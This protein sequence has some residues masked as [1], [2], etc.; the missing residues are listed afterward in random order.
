MFTVQSS[1][2]TE[3]SVQHAPA[4]VATHEKENGKKS[5]NRGDQDCWKTEVKK[6]ATDNLFLQSFW[7]PFKEE[8]VKNWGKK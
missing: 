7:L 4:T 1:S 6:A 2:K 5:K 8:E 3:P